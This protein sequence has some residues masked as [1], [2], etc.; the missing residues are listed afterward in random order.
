MPDHR[1]IVEVK[2]IEGKCPI[3]KVGD[4]Y[5]IEAQKI[6]IDRIKVGSG[7]LC[8]HAVAGLYGTVMM[9]RSGPA[10][11]KFI[12]QCLDPGPPYVEGGGRVIFEIRAEKNLKRRKGKTQK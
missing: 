10:G 4:R 3:Y 9:A 6:P 1:V 7:M 8:I 5:V 12:N 11:K 2:A